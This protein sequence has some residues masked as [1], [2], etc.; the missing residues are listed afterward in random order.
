MNL[1]IDCVYKLNLTKN[2]IIILFDFENQR[3]QRIAKKKYLHKLV[4]TEA[5][6]YRAFLSLNLRVGIHNKNLGPTLRIHGA[7]TKSNL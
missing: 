3:I 7:N 6:I 1:V 5:G 2:G 4:F